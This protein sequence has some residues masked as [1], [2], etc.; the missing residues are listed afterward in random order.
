MVKDA[1]THAEEDKK[2]R[3]LVDAKNQAEAMIHGAEKAIKDLGEKAD[4]NDVEK[5]QKA[6]AE[7][8]TEIKTDNV[9]KI[10]E[11]TMQLTEAAG[12]I[13]Q[14]AYQEQAAKKDTNESG[15]K[16]KKADENV[17]DADF[18]EVDEEKKDEPKKDSK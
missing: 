12:K 11:K 17:V 2:A 7:L 13:A 18:K 15:E 5:T 1:E 9:E 16:D 10:K 6:I 3:E 14:Q 8:K 4:K